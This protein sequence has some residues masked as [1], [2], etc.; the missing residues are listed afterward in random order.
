MDELLSIV[1]SGQRVCLLCFERDP[2]H[3]HRSRIAEDRA[4]RI[5]AKVT[6]L[7]PDA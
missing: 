1:R 3:C 6:D 7:M 2:G 4:E 5:G